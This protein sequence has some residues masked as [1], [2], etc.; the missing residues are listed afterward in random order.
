MKIVSE[1]FPKSHKL[2][3]ILNRNTTKISYSCLPNIGSKILADA[4]NKYK[5]PTVDFNPPCIGH[6]N[7][8]CPVVGGKCNLKNNVYNAK[9]V[10]AES[11]Y[12]YVGISENPLRM[13]IAT[14]KYSI[15]TDK[16]Q[17][18]LSAKAK[19]LESKN[20]TYQ[21]EYHI[22]E[23]SEA[24]KPEIKRC[25]LCTVEIYYIIFWGFENLINSKMELTGKCCHRNKYK[26]GTGWQDIVTDEHH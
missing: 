4:S 25:K 8:S 18:E 11:I 3:K 1:S 5:G 16:N 20:I 14:H 13:R 6:R 10:T 12:N 23:N 24:Y 22:L 15:K 17:T 19:E 7:N 26:I 21:I 9:L 2:S